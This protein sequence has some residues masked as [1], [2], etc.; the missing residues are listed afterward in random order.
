VW[1]DRP[2]LAVGNSVFRVGQEWCNMQQ[3]K[4]VLVRTRG[5]TVAQLRNDIDSGRTGDKVD[6]I[7]PAAAPLGTD[8]EAAGRS[9][10]PRHIRRTRLVEKRRPRSKRRQYPVSSTGVLGFIALLVG[11]AALA[12]WWFQT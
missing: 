10:S 7:D 5:D 3:R 12:T 9:P 8:E 6:A 4:E 2:S 11:L 1:N